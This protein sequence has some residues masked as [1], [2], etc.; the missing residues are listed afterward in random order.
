MHSSLL[1]VVEGY[2]K[3]Y[4]SACS[5]VSH[6]ILGATSWYDLLLYRSLLL[7]E[8]TM[9]KIVV[10]SDFSSSQGSSNPSASMH[11]YGYGYNGTRLMNLTGS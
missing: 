7:E 11:M 10:L 2:V 4:P 1:V 5:F 6:G 9:L 3:D 8:Y